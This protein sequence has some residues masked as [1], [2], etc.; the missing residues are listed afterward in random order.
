[1]N[2]PYKP[3]LTFCFNVD[4]QLWEQDLRNNQLFNRIYDMNDAKK[5]QVWL[6]PQQTSHNY[7]L[8]NQINNKLEYADK[9][10]GTKNIKIES[11]LI[12]PKN[13]PL[14]KDCLTIE[15][16]LNL[17][18]LQS[19]SN[20]QIYQKY[21]RHEVNSPSYP[22]LDRNIF[23]NTTKEIHNSIDDRN[24]LIIPENKIKL[25]ETFF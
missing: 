2:N 14:T 22:N 7:Y 15:E 23:D 24:Q 21:H 25:N 16:A 10:C 11:N 1:M 17:T 20:R 13:T 5:N 4:N 8:S 9:I 12:F 3:L 6:H 19:S 18:D